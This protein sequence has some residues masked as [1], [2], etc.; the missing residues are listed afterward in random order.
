MLMLTLSS[1]LD[2][3]G[4]L[5]YIG[6]LNTR[7]IFAAPEAVAE[8]SSDIIDT[9]R[10]YKGRKE[11]KISSLDLHAPF[12]PLCKDRQSLLTAM[13]DGGRVGFNAPYIPRDC[14][15][16]W[17][18]TQQICSILARFEKVYIVGDS[19]MRNIASALNILLREDLQSGAVMDW[20]MDDEK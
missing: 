2:Y 12:S 17:F 4:R 18:S 9:F 19:L 16:R 11:C 3:T 5:P 13:K 1:K 7:P 10:S 14:D 20:M 6:S 15:M 8:R